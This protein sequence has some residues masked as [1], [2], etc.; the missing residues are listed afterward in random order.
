M[1]KPKY[2]FNQKT[3]TYERYFVNW[4]KRLLGVL[5]FLLT[6]G[7]LAV[8]MMVVASRFFGSPQERYLKRELNFMKFQYDMLNDRFTELD[9]VLKELEERDNNIYRVIFEAEPVPSSVR[10]AGIGGTD[11]YDKM[12]GYT[13]SELV[14]ESAKR[15]DRIASQLYVQ[16][17]SFDEVFDLAKRKN[18][19]VASIPAIRPLKDKDFRR[20]SSF[21]G[22]RTDPFYK[23]SKLHAG[24]DFSTPTGTDVFATGD[25]T[26]ETVEKSY[27]GY[28]NTIVINHGFGYRTVY[29]HLSAF[30]VKKGEKVKRGQL[31][32]RTGNSGKST[33]PHLHYEV[34]KNNVPV[35]PIHFFFN[36]LTPSEYELVLEL[37]T[38]QT[39]SMD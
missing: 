33:S 16:S 6:T 25:G 24:L 32:A 12:K 14:T 2:V 35:N 3:L 29:G 4:K 9:G 11:R 30:K 34:R 19:L 31:I 13:N 1:A 20:I 39:Q 26:V 38:A 27:Y 21:F 5:Y 15:L 23:V 36:D 17:K 8:A 37:S 28:G 10:R 18:E 7:A 22:Y